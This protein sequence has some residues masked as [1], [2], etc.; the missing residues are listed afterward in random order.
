MCR[1]LVFSLDYA[2]RRID[3]VPPVQ[4]ETDGL[5]FRQILGVEKRQFCMYLNDFQHDFFTD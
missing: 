5:K 3:L 4:E 2:E 1:Q